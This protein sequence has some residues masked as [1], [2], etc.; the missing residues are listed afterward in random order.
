MQTNN[1]PA[2][3]NRL[4]SGWLGGFVLFIALAES[5]AAPA[6]LRWRWSNPRPHGGNIV[7]MAF[8]T[9]LN[10]AVQVAERG[11]IFTSTD[12]GFWIPRDTGT[13]NDLRAVCFFGQRILVTGE[14]GRVL[15][16]M[17]TTPDD[18]RFGTT[19][20]A[21]TTDWLEAVAASPLTAVAVGDN[22]AV[23]TTATG[24]NWTKQTSGTAE[25]LRGVAWGNTMGGGSSVFVAVGENG[26]VIRSYAGSSWSVKTSITAQHL[27]R[28]AFT[29][30]PTPRFI[31]VGEAGVCFYSLNNGTNWTPEVTGATNDLFHASSAG[32]FSGNGA[33]LA[34]G[35]SEVRMQ[36]IGSGWSNEVASVSGPTPWTYYTSL[37]RPNYFLIA[38]RTGLMEEC[39]KT[40]GAPHV[41]QPFDQSVRN[42]FWDVTYP[43]NLYVTV[44]DRATVLTSL[45]GVDWRPEVVPEALTNSIFLGVG[46]NT[47]ML[48]AAGERGSLMFSPNVETNFVVSDTNGTNVTM[49]TTNGSA[50]GV[51]WYPADPP[52]TNDLQ[53]VAA[54]S[55]LFVVSGA[56][57]TILT[58]PDATN[59]ASI[60]PVT[61]R[62]L[63]GLTAWPRGWIAT[64]DDGVILSSASGTSW[65]VVWSPNSQTTNWLYRVRYLNGRLIAVG[66]YGFIATSTNG[67]NWT[68][69]NFAATGTTKWL[70]D[71]TWVNGTYYVVG[72]SGTVLTSTN[73]T[74]WTSVGTLTR[75]NLYAAATDSAQLVTV[76][77][78]GVILRAQVVADTNAVQFLSYDHLT[79]TNQFGVFMENL[80]LFGGSTDQ[81]FSVDNRLDFGTNGW[82]AGPQLEFYD[83]SGTLFYLEMIA[84]TNSPPREFYRN[85]LLLP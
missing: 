65:Q 35:D 49:F 24:T 82:N 61:T 36:E 43:T 44:G 26:T 28:V 15:W 80:Y 74:N 4:H 21:S 67:T 85:H 27:T 22:G 77:V 11:Q 30:L 84:L 23:Y 58:S 81:Q 3:A 73:A 34:S 78:E 19:T 64:G 9:S 60:T 66:Q 71:V 20:P 69:F 5:A 17:A 62:F 37:G 55:N 7:D 2:W 48:I 76:G 46:G 42:W 47:N 53:G 63:S 50:F 14:N 79:I 68:K 41:W 39:S 1:R 70:N 6:P 33:R 52:T 38:G 29:S 40:N 57:G 83:G 31:A 56:N 72:N 75:K 8:S 13:S 59:W 54:T 32:G 51:L 16:A 18:W 45:N 25:W 12:L 10:L